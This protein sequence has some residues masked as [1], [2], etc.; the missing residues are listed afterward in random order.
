MSDTTSVWQS[1]PQPDH[2]EA[3]DSTST[4]PGRRSAPRTAASPARVAGPASGRPIVRAAAS[5]SSPGAAQRA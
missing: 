1:S 2:R 3:A 5:V 4:R